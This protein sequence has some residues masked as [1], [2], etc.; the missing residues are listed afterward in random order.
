MIPQPADSYTQSV[1]EECRVPVSFRGSV[2]VAASGYA[3]EAQI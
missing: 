1:D 3:S 2:A